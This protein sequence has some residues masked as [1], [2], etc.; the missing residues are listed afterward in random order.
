MKTATLRC[1]VNRTNSTCSDQC[2]S[3]HAAA[4]YGHIDILDYLISKGGDVNVTDDD[5]DTP[6]Y[7]VEN[8]ET[9]RYLVERG[10]VVDRRNLEGVSPIEYLS[11]DFEEVAA[12]LQTKSSLPPPSSQP[13]STNPSQHAQDAASEQLTSELMA[14]VHE[15]MQRGEQDGCDVDSQLAQAVTRAVLGGV[16]AGY[17]L[18][19]G[20][21]DSERQR[22]QA[23]TAEDTSSTKRP[24]ID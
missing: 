13:S 19:D 12:Y 21:T 3:R 15:I 11:D 22:N 17:Q 16:E 23:P 20:T 1:T 2:A 5:G 7:T 6:L 24:R 8:V 10:A 14:S 9:A 18:A 4:S